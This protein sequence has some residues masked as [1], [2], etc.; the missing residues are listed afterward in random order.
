ML[1]A[2]IQISV[3]V[4]HDLKL[5]HVQKMPKGY[6]ED[7]RW[8]VVFMICLQCM[9]IAD[10]AKTLYKSHSTVERLVHLYRTTGDTCSNSVK[11]G[12]EKKLSDFEK[13]TVVQSFVKLPWN[14]LER[15]AR[16]F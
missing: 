16:T 14:L 6:S 1:R 10:V 12:P 2:Q 5:L 7:F 11:H 3:A 8:R 13:L 4:V 9:I 15:G